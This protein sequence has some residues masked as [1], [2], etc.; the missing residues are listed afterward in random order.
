MLIAIE[1]IDGAGKTTLAKL[2]AVAL[3]AP[4]LKFPD[5]NTATGAV[6]D[7][8]LRHKLTIP[9]LA[10]QALQV[11]NRLEKY[12]WLLT[13]ALSRTHH[14]VCDRYTDSGLVYGMADG[15][16]RAALEAMQTGLPEADLHFLI[17]V[18]P[19]IIDGQ[20]L[21]GRDREVYENKG[22]QGL[23]DQ[24][25]RFHKMWGVK[26]ARYPRRWIVLDGS[27]QAEDLAAIVVGIVRERTVR[28]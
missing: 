17:Q 7:E 9:P 12:D 4:Y 8:V 5:R 23:S 28:R 19:E 26:I 16:D 13:A 21:A 24:A 18:D 11:C 25:E 14:V 15:L 10:F 22:L 2:V 3:D 6:L 1:G 27:R 20:R